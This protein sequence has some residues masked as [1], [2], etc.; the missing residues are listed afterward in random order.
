[1]ATGGSGGGLPNGQ[2]HKNQVI[3]IRGD[4]DSELQALFDSVLAPNA[5]RRPKQVPLR[6]RNLPD[7]FFN[8]P[9]IGSKS[10]SC[11]VSHSRENSVDSTLNPVRSPL[12][13]AGASHSRAHSSP[14]TLEQTYSVA[15][16]LPGLSLSQSGSANNLSDDP[17]PPGWEQACTPEG[18]IYF[19]N[20]ITR[21][22]TWE[23]PRKAQTQQILAAIGNGT[24]SLSSQ[25]NHSGNVIQ[26]VGSAVGPLP[27]G[28]EQAITPEGEIYFIDHMNRTTSWFDPRIPMHLQRPQVLQHQ[29]NAAALAQASALAA[30]SA[31]AISA[32]SNVN[33]AVTSAAGTASLLNNNTSI[34]LSRQQEVRLQQLQLERE[35]LKLRQQEIMQ[36][37]EKEQARLRQQNRL[38]QM[39]DGEIDPFLGGSMVNP[40]TPS[41]D[42]HSRQESADS[43]LGMGNS[44]SLPN[45]PEDFLSNMDDNMDT[46]SESIDAPDIGTLGND[47]V[48]STDDLVPS[49]DISEL[50]SELSNELLDEMQ[51]IMNSS[52][53]DNTMT[54][55]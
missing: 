37:M 21:S 52:R 23:D 14:A 7:S 8:P 55:L 2:S 34:Q 38:Q 10:P 51:T 19:I 47:N 48:E 11:S 12:S 25:A 4:S 50:N 1:M 53:S 6:L 39:E 3:H 26:A 35:R 16:A 46:I 29:I 54:W 42:F 40:S 15:A 49:L 45:T 31:A 22:T 5:N 28:W 20:H 13:T 30:A 24:G 41:S 18:Q 36:Q 17:L 32:S 9:S 27:E 33:T 43:G 44:Y